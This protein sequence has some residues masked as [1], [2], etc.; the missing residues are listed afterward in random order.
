[1]MVALT[2]VTLARPLGAQPISASEPRPKAHRTASV[3]K[4]LAGAALG[5]AVHESAHLV[6]DFAFDAKPGIKRVELGGIPFFAITH[7]SDLSPRRELAISSAGFWVQEAWNEILLTRRP[8]LRHANAPMAK[9]ALAFNI[10]TSIGYAAVAFG[11]TGPVERDTRGMADSA[12]VDE[13]AIAALVLAPAL[14]DGYRYFRPEAAWAKWAAR[15]AKLGSAALVLK[16]T[17]D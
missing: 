9:G 5:L 17:S 3:V 8:M 2:L 10:L 4:F 1:M 14:L 13:R 7:R 6:L 11:R 16:S 15:A 12:G